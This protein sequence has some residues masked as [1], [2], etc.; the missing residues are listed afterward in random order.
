MITKKELEYVDS[1][2]RKCPNPGKNYSE[3]TLYMLKEAV[4][5]YRKLYLGRNYS[6]IFSNGEE[7]QY[8][9]LEKNLAHML[10]I[11]YKNI[12]NEYFDQFRKRILGLD[13]GYTFSSYQLLCSIIENIDKLIDYDSHNGCKAINYYK[14]RIKCEIFGKL[15][16][17]S[18]FNF[19]CINFNPTTYERIK[20]KPFS[21][22][23]TKFLFVPSNEGVCPYF[24][25]G[26]KED[27]DSI[28]SSSDSYD[29]TE[30]RNNGYITETS[31]APSTPQNFFQEQEFIIPTQI[32]MSTDDI[33]EKMNATPEEK[34]NLL[35]MY[36][37]II[38]KYGLP[39]M[40]NIQNDYEVLLA[41]ASRTRHN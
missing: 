37:A 25:I 29:D 17:F 14:V 21:G 27:A 15:S 4:D 2:A 18:K 41:E 34:I 26:I 11:D 13:N 16:D 5:T 22:N 40:L 31:I 30:P 6:I 38:T 23:S 19:G 3:E 35:N 10:G 39:N 33:L 24:M 32:L 12:S 36:K 20:G 9:L 8:E 28:T 1:W 7:I